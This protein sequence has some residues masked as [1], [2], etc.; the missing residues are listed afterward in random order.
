MG[1]YSRLFIKSFFKILRK[2]GLRGGL[3]V[4]LGGF[5]E[6]WQPGKLTSCQLDHA[7]L[8]LLLNQVVF[9]QESVNINHLCLPVKTD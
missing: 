7:W 9:L 2:L 8:F 1:A 3:L 4:A 5:I 6:K